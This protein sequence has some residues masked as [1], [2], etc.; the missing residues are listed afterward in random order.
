MTFP[1]GSWS[2]AYQTPGYSLTAAVTYLPEA[3][4]PTARKPAGR[5]ASVT[6]GKTAQLWV[7]TPVMTSPDESVV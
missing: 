6:A 3:P 7:H 1:Q 2:A 4:P 5:A